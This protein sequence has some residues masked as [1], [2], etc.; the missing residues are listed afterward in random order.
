MRATIAFLV[1]L[2]VMAIG[3]V[4]ILAEAPIAPPAEKVEQVIPDDRIPR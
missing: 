1:F 2:V 3:S 4:F